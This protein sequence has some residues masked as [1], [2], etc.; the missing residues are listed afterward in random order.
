[1][2]A[3]GEKF[4]FSSEDLK[5][6]ANNVSAATQYLGYLQNKYGLDLRTTLAYYNRGETRANK[7]IKKQG[8]VYS[9]SLNYADVIIDCAKQLQPPLNKSDLKVQ[10][11]PAL[12]P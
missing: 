6:V 10:S 11:V 3:T 9:G 8:L 2:P 12:K 1:M 5:L 7:D 4:G